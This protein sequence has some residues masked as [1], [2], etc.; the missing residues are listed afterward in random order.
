MKR[1]ASLGAVAVAALLFALAYITGVKGVLID[2]IAHTCTTLQL[3]QPLALV[4][5]ALLAAAGIASLYVAL[6]AFQSR[7]ESSLKRENRPHDQPGT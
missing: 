3:P 2:C 7:S 4:M 6:K 5:G 1:L